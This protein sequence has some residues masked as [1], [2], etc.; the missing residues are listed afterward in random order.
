MEKSRQEMDLTDGVEF[1]LYPPF[2]TQSPSQ[3]EQSAEQSNVIYAQ[4]GPLKDAF[5]QRGVQ[6]G[7]GNV[8]QSCTLLYVLFRGQRSSLS[9]Q[10]SP[11]SDRRVQDTRKKREGEQS[12]VRIN[13]EESR[14]GAGFEG[15][16]HKRQAAG[17]AGYIL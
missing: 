2:P 15:E 13:R 3:A 17:F 9:S 8:T 1:S 11:K 4:S 5:P 7:D 6:R 14:E 12:S 16:T 10:S